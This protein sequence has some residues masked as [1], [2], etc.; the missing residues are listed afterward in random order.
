MSYPYLK[1]Y[2]HS[3]INHKSGQVVRHS[4][5]PIVNIR[6]PIIRVY[7]LDIKQ[8]K[9]FKTEPYIFHWVEFTHPILAPLHESSRRSYIHT[10]ICLSAQHCLITLRMWW[11]KWQSVRPHQFQMHLIL[12]VIWYIVLKE[13]RNIISLLVWS[14]NIAGI[15]LSKIVT[16]IAIC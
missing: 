12:G 2:R 1:P 7:I 5:L 13:K 8:I 3:E 16:N 4:I 15:H 14:R 11:P 9:Q 10:V 6:N